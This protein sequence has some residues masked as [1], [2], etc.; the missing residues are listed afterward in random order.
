MGKILIIIGILIILVGLFLEFGIKVPFIG[1]LP[2]D[3]SME[4]K[5]FQLYIPISSSIVIS[6]FLMLIFLIIRWMKS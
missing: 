6:L 1:K 3:I 2:G 5:N 4:R